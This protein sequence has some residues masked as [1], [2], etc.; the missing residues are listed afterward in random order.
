M[1]AAQGLRFA[2]LLD[3]KR[4]EKIHIPHWIGSPRAYSRN[5]VAQCQKGLP[6][7]VVK[8]LHTTTHRRF[9]RV[10]DICA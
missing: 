1:V 8:N 9:K 5:H 6:I 7:E 2:L 3:R 10:P 4:C